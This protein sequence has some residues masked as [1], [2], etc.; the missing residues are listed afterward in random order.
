MPLNSDSCG[1]IADAA[2]ACLEEAFLLCIPEPGD[3]VYVVDAAKRMK[4]EDNFGVHAGQQ[5]AHAISLR[6]QKEGII[7]AVRDSSGKYEVTRL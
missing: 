1:R 7:A 4:L 3:K 5:C 6:L 2:L